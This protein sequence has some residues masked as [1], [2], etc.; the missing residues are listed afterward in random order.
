MERKNHAIPGYKGFVP[1]FKNGT[2]LGQRFTEAPRET[3][4]KEGMDDRQQT[5]SS[6][7]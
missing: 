4:S 1:G 6:T 7:G 5:F 2:L 3:F